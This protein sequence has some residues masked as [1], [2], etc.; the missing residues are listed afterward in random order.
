MKERFSK[1]DQIQILLAEYNTLRA[2]IIQKGIAQIQMLTVTGTAVVAI[3][4]FAIVYNAIYAGAI[5][6]IVAL[7]LM[8]FGILYNHQDIGIIATH[9]RKL[10]ARINNLIGHEL[11]SWEGK[12]GGG[13]EAISHGERLR[14]LF[15]GSSN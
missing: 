13:L 4:G 11:L 1:R 9:V 8:S 3:L 14:R 2:E 12:S 10:E 6:L 15:A 7:I 5:L